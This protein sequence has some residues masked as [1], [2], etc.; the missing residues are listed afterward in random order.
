MGLTC[1]RA[2]ILH[3]EVGGSYGGSLEALRAYLAHCD[4]DRFEHDVLFYFPTPGNDAIRP[5]AGRVWSAFNQAPAAHSQLRTRTLSLF[6]PYCPSAWHAG[7]KLF[8]ARSIARVLRETMLAGR[9]DLV[10]VNNSFHYQPASILAASRMGLPVVGHVRNPVPNVAATRFLL[11][12]LTRIVTVSRVYEDPIRALSGTCKVSTCYDG[13]ELAAANP[14][15][16]ASFRKRLALNGGALIGSLGRLDPQKGYRDL[17]RAARQVVDK[18][19]DVSF[20]VA[21]EG[22]ERAMLEGQI[23]ATGLGDHFHLCGF[24]SEVASFLSALDLFVSSSHWEGLPLAVV[25]A[26]QAR[27]PVVA[28]RVGGTP[29]IVVPEETGTLIPPSDPDALA[30]A[31]LRALSHPADAARMASRGLHS[32]MERFAPAANAAALDDVFQDALASSR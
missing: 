12:H 7:W 13:V 6:T 3:I 8:R 2:R 23:A 16:A 11:R 10:H 15:G 22:C 30:R 19:P 31:I 29:E 26:M 14:Q 17:I 32:V 20:A 21:G 5:L 24:R 18:R 1:R 4:R 28:T 27:V 25:Q 9:Y